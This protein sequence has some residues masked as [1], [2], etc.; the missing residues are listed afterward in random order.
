[1]QNYFARKGIK[2]L[3]EI[4]PGEIQLFQVFMMTDHNSRSY[5]NFLNLLKSM[6]NKAVEWGIIK[7]NPIYGRKLLKVPKKVRFFSKGE[8]EKLFNNA[9]TDMKLLFKYR[10]LRWIAP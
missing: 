3:E 9:E 7:S 8:I 6:L 10:P 4:T 1:M 5:N 2:Y